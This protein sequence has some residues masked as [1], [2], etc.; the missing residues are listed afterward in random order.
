MTR[1]LAEFVS[2]L[3]YSDIPGDAIEMA[4]ICFLDFLGVA[5]RGSSERSGLMALRAMGKGSGGAT[6]IGHGRG[7]AE[8]AALLN[9]IF[10]HN[11]DLD[12]GHRG[13]QMHPG[14]CVI[15]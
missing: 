2:S 8:R 9:G 1:R 6:I 10:A 15:P 3:S 5:M 11:L 13:A 12:D 14:S 4:R 7:D